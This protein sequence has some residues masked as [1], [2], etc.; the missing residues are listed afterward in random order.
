MI[1]LLDHSVAFFIALL[2]N[3]KEKTI[4]TFIELRSTK[5][6]TFVITFFLKKLAKNLL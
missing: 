3:K 4:A 6:A 1:I 5:R 2:H